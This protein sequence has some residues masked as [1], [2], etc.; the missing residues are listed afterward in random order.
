MTFSF[1]ALEFER[2][3]NLLSRFVSSEDARTAIADIQ[4]STEITELESE[5]ELTAEA[6]AFLRVNRVPFREIQCFSE[7]MEK[8]QVSGTSLEIPEIEAVQSFLIHIEG[9]RTRWK[10]E[11]AA[12]P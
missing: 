6:M 9:L 5:H 7:A 1:N 11:A 4:P 10:D 12:F 2:L 8:I 3:K